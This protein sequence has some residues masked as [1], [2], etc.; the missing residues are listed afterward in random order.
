MI[1]LSINHSSPHLKLL[2]I[3]L[4]IC[5]YHE[6][7]TQDRDNFALFFFTFYSHSISLSIVATTYLFFLFFFLFWPQPQHMEVSGSGIKSELQLRPKPHLCQWRILNSLHQSRNS[8]YTYTGYLTNFLI[9]PAGPI[10]Q[11]SDTL[12]KHWSYIIHW[13]Q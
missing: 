1:F 12:S 4:L 5:V 3:H 6:D 7:G 9:Y 2:G 11:I 8:L 13:K 10:V